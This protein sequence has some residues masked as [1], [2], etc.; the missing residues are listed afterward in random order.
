MNP[1]RPEVGAR[2]RTLRS[3]AIIGSASA[4][5][6]LG[7]SIALHLEWYPDNLPGYIYIG[8]IVTIGA[9]TTHRWPL[10]TLSIVAAYTAYTALG[11]LPPELYGLYL[12][13]PESL[14]PLAVVSFLAISGR[15]P[16]FAT[17]A[18]F[19]T[20]AVLLILPWWDIVAMVVGHQPLSQALLLNSGLDRSIL[21]AELIASALVVLVAVMLR[22]QR[23][24]TAELARNNRELSELREAQVA[25][26]AERER[27]RIARDVHDEVAH[28]VAALVIRAQAAIRISDRHPEEL[29]RAVRDIADGGQDVLARICAVVR[30]LK[31]SLDSTAG[32]EEAPLA[33]EFETLFERIRS[34]GYEVHGSV[35]VPND[36][37]STHRS[38]LLSV[39]QES[40]T[41]TMHSASTEVRV[42]VEE[43][44]LAWAVTVVDP[45][46]A[47]E[48]FPQVPRGGSGIPSMSERVGVLGGHL[49]TGTHPDGSGWT[50]HAQLPRTIAILREEVTI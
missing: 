23:R 25:R 44:A 13:P 28:H 42:V 45:G 33:V 41:N 47:K 18:T 20:L 26:I 30:I 43:T 14:M 15:G 40:L 31:P 24:A 3:L 6:F 36:M 19:L 35:S 5:Y 27:T 8:I 50:V 2:A 17:A 12:S 11:P 1:S 9:A 10:E 4:A 29:G 32:I 22:R 16:V 39:V 34:I 48:R 7:L 46:P 21:L 37:P 38:A 49:T